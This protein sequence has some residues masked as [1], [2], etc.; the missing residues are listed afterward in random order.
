MNQSDYFM[1]NRSKEDKDALRRPSEGSAFTWL[2]S[3]HALLDNFG[4]FALALLLVFLTLWAYV[5]SHAKLLWFD[6]LLGL[7]IADLPTL[8]EVVGALKAQADYSAPLYHLVDHATI[9]TL[10]YSRSEER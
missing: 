2:L 8:G 7:T 6:E 1:Y 3:A 5:A 10:G 4:A 9:R